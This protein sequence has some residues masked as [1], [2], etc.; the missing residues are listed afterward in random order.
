M[1]YLS[2]PTHDAV[3]Q[4][5]QTLISLFLSNVQQ[6]NICIP[7]QCLQLD[8]ENS[9]VNYLQCHLRWLPTVLSL[10]TSWG[11]LKYLRVLEGKC[12]K[13]KLTVNFSCMRCAMKILEDFTKRNS[14]KSQKKAITPFLNMYNSR[15]K[16][17][18]LIEMIVKHCLIIAYYIW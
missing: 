10:H 2:L 1:C 7:E 15:R 6:I 13:S 5:L 3:Q 14:R 18:L 8:I 16:P 17:N 11:W 9:M 4:F 12:I